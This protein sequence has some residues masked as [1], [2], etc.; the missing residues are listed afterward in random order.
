MSCYK[1]LPVAFVSGTGIWLT[2]STGQRYFDALSGIAVCGLGH[3]HPEINAAITDQ[4]SKLIHTSN[5]YQIPLQQDLAKKL[6]SLARMDK[7]FFSNSG[8]EANETAIKI[9]RL[10]GHQ[11][12]IAKSVII[13][14]IG[15]FHG[16]T[17]ATLSATGNLK[18]Q[19]NFVPTVEKFIHIP[20]NDVQAIK[21]VKN[22]NVV[23]VM[24]EPIQG[25]NGVIVPDQN[26]LRSIRHI[27]DENN[28]LLILDEVQT[29]M[30]RTGKWFCH[31]YEEVVPDIMTL[32]KALGN[33]VPIGACLAK[34]KAAN[35]LQP[36]DH[37][38]TFGGNHLASRVGLA[39]IDVL[40]KDKLYLHAADIGAKILAAFKDNLTEVEGVVSVRGRGLMLGIELDRKC[41]ELV[42]MAL[43]EKILINVTTNNVIRILPPLIIDNEAAQ[44][45]VDKI[46]HVIKVFLRS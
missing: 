37:G 1:R 29:G 3:A 19:S 18:M 44:Q 46:V 2:D 41:T 20:Y 40:S 38:S 16:R 7:V 39:V 22:E 15:S 31:Q 30:C 11:Q 14:A 35:L 5:L 17:M 13:T 36:G 23:A 4:V 8:A 21:N 27:C 34:G 6:A 9:A 32:A 12:G 28:W 26:Y 42:T 10:F 25:E 45:L 43:Q 24:L 33:G